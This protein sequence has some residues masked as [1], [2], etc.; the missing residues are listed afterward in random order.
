MNKEWPPRMERSDASNLVGI[1]NHAAG[2]IELS[3]R[4]KTL[5]GL[6]FAVI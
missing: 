4:D 3:H 1:Y 2:K 5:T 6:D